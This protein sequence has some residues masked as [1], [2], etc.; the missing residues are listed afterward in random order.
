MEV[1]LRFKDGGFFDLHRGV[2]A[3]P[4]AIAADLALATNVMPVS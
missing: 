2:S 3:P 4:C 1:V